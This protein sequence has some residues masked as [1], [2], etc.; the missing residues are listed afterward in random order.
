VLD[1][2]LA[3]EREQLLG[4]SR[5]EPGA[6]AAAEYHRHHAFH[7]H[8]SGLYLVLEARFLAVIRVAD[9]AEVTVLSQ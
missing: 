6:C 2:G 1:Q 9:Y 3:V 5:A 8:I 7:R 4:Q